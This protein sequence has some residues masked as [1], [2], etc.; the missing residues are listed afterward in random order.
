M[1]RRVTWEGEPASRFPLPTLATKIA[2]LAPPL[3]AGGMDPALRPGKRLSPGP[4]S[5]GS[6]VASHWARSPLAALA[7][8]FS[9]LLASCVTVRPLPPTFYVENL[10]S[11]KISQL[12]LEDRILVEETWT[13]IRQGDAVRAEKLIAKMGSQ[14]PFYLVGLGYVS[15]LNDQLPAAETYFKQELKN[16]PESTLAHAGLAQIYLKTGQEDQAFNEYLEVL[17]KEPENPWALKEFEDLKSKL[18]EAHLEEAR[19][20][21]AAGDTAQ[22]KAAFLKLLNY[23]PKDLEAHLGL[24]RLYLQD[25]EMTNA[26]FHYH[27]AYTLD[28]KNKDTVKEYADCLFAAGQN[29]RS[30]DMYQEYLELDPKNKEVKDRVENLKNRLGI[31][32]LPSQYQSIPSSM[33]VTREE[34]AALIAVK[35]KPYLENGQAKPPVIIDVATSWASRQIMKVASLGIM[36]GYAN[37]TFQ[38]RQAVSRAEMAE[39]LTRLISLLKTKGFRFVRQFPEEMIQISDVSPDNYYFQPIAEVVALQLMELGPDKSFKP[40]QT[41]SGQEAINIFDLILSLIK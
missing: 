33:A 3:L 21:L 1:T 10:P 12:S 30:L 5:S 25:K 38:P 41:L 2:R 16:D 34:V 31:F 4:L 19:S 20:Y 14:N 40:E 22:A 6:P 15:F 27:T 9:L 23:S 39:I 24:A 36:Q 13:R 11:D 8:A 29:G 7:A 17:K 32:E 35:F 28:P 18:T 37:H 26:L